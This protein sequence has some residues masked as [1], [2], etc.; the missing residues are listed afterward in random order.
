MVELIATIGVK[1]AAVM[2]AN[3]PRYPIH[4][5]FD[6]KPA[7]QE[8]QEWVLSF[9]ED[10]QLEGLGAGLHMKNYETGHAMFFGDMVNCLLY[11]HNDVTVDWSQLED[12]ITIAGM[13]LAA[14]AETTVTNFDRAFEEGF[15]KKALEARM[16][17][18]EELFKRTDSDDEDVRE[19]FLT[20]KLGLPKIEKEPEKKTGLTLVEDTDGTD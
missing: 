12:R 6:I 7:L 16:S 11:L 19:E 14:L 5:P 9:T 17:I 8:P 4:I 10:S 20:K 1:L 15:S 13:Q 2:L 3:N 18:E